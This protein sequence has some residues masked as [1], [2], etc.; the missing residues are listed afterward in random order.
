VCEVLSI[1]T[2]DLTPSR[3]DCGVPERGCGKFGEE[4]PIMF[5][6]PEGQ[7]CLEVLKCLI[8]GRWEEP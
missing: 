3:I 2:K 6:V 1:T 8:Q 5:I 4:V 7:K